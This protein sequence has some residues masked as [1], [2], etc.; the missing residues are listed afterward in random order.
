MFGLD[1]ISAFLTLY[2]AI[3]NSGGA[4][5]FDSWRSQQAGQG[6]AVLNNIALRLIQIH[7]CVVYLFAGLGKIQGVSWWNGQAIWGAIASYEYQTM[8]MTWLADHMWLV[9]AIT[10][11]AVVWEVSYCALVWPKLSRPI[12]L[13]IALFVHLGIGLVMGMMTFGLV[14][15]FGNIAFIAPNW[16]REVLPGT[17]VASNG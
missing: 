17:G 15:I 13:V 12:V 6:R 2:L 8:D 16:F 4:Y 11:A 1:Q 14:M 9:N 5:S 10:L 7:M 3:G